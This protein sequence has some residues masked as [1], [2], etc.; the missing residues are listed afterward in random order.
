MTRDPAGELAARVVVEGTSRGLVAVG[1]TDV[2]PF[3]DVRETLKRR[4][5]EGAAGK[6]TFTYRDPATAT[7]VRRSF[8]WARRLVVG[9]AAYL[10]DAGN[11]GPGRSSSGRIARFAVQDFY[12]RVVK[13]LEAIAALLRKESFRAEILCDDNRLVDRAAAVRAGVGWWGKNSMVL[14]PG[15]GPWLLLGSVVTDAELPGTGPMRRD[16]GTCSACLPACPTGAL[17]EPGVLDASKCLAHWAQ[18]PGVIPIEL[19]APMGDRIYGCDDCLEACPPGR[20]LLSEATSPG[21]GRVDLA[22]LLTAPDDELL[23]HYGHF[24]IPRRRARYLRRNALVALGNTGTADDVPLLTEFL[25][26]SD[27][28]LRAHAAWALG[29]VGAGRARESLQDRLGRETDPR[30]AEEIRWALTEHRVTA[31]PGRR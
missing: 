5:A 3:A 20:R 15:Y 21:R 6:L 27:W 22:P 7:D 10:P 2:E 26:H 24:Y 19:R 9:A 1:I 25:E 12:P 8:S 4:L 14:A 30:V 31:T 17:I 28:L 16:C 23:T 29:R 11:P 13:P 18:V